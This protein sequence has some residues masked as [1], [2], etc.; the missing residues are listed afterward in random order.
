[1]STHGTSVAAP[2]SDQVTQLLLAWGA[3]DESALQQLVP[4]VHTELRR[5][6]RRQMRRERDDHT[7]QTTALVNEV[8]L[9]MVDLSR[10]RWQ[11]RAHFF[12]MA[13]RLMRRVLVD[14]ARSRRYQKRGGGAVKV[15]ITQALGVRDQIAPDIVA[16]S[17]ALDTL[18][19]VDERKSK[20]VELRFFGG[21]SVRETA[22]SLGVSEETVMRDWRLAKAWL[23]RELSD[24]A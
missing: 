11:D 4:L 3:G 12:A 18:A 2:L 16:L 5:M 8:Y 6:A 1:M 22:E 15:S 7:L 17:D 20:V 24:G 14:H 21:L 10:V 13:S 19:A 9:R 23:L